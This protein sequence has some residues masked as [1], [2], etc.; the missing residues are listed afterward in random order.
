M[1]DKWITKWIL[2]ISD[3][4][5]LGINN[6]FYIYLNVFKSTKIWI[7]QYF[8]DFKIWILLPNST[9]N[10]TVAAQETGDS[11]TA[12]GTFDRQT[13]MQIV[14]S[15]QVRGRYENYNSR[16]SDE[17]QRADSNQ[18]ISQTETGGRMLKAQKDR[19]LR[20]SAEPGPAKGQ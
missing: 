16:Q 1:L 7:T 14:W 18:A 9:F 13:T 4:C 8:T 15:R 3:N 6:E 2:L 19:R 10:L 17:R 12:D 20:S 11:S 5:P